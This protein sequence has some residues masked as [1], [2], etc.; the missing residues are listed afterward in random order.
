MKVTD[1]KCFVTDLSKNVTG[2]ELTVDG[3][4]TCQLY[5]QE[6]NVLKRKALEEEA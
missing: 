3:G 6:L 4:M 1:V 5:P 2:A